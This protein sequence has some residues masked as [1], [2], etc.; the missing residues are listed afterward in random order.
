MITGQLEVDV[1]ALAITSAHISNIAG[2]VA[3]NGLFQVRMVYQF[4]PLQIKVYS[5]IHAVSH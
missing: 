3:E 2:A 1:S 5:S 4:G